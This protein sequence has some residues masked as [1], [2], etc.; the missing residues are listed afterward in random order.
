MVASFINRAAFRYPGVMAF[1]L[2]A[3]VTW[4]YVAT[5]MREADKE[6]FTLSRSWHPSD[7]GRPAVLFRSEADAV[8]AEESMRGDQTASLR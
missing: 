1:I 8:A 7:L 6:L 3:L 4:V 5:E 2:V